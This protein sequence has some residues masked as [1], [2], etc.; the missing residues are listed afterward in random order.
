MGQLAPR[1]KDTEVKYH[2]IGEKSSATDWDEL[3]GPAAAP[4]VSTPVNTP[5]VI[6]SPASPGKA[7]SSPPSSQKSS[8]DSSQP[9]T[10][11]SA[12]LWQKSSASTT[13]PEQESPIN[14]SKERSEPLDKPRARMSFL[15]PADWL[16]KA[17]GKSEVH[18][19]VDGPEMERGRQRRR[20]RKTRKTETLRASAHAGS[21]P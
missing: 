14:T 5:A 12:E 6:V 2:E 7:S 10:P 3:P 18:A 21:S 13:S 11:L 16:S 20:L 4:A 8:H 17:D 9:Q 15:R 1:N 19:L